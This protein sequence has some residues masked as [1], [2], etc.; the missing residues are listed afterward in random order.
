MTVA[1]AVT[2]CSMDTRA[3][4]GLAEANVGSTGDA[5]GL[6]AVL[7]AVGTGVLAAVTVFCTYDSLDKIEAAQR[8]GRTVPD[9]RT[10]YTATIR[11]TA[12]GHPLGPLQRLRFVVERPKVR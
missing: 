6:A 12:G 9:R 4:Q 5:A 2:V 10:E 7:S 1:V 11:V 3:H 8:T